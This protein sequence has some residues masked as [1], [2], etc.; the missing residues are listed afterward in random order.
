MLFSNAVAKVRT[1]VKRAN[2][3]TIFVQIF[4]SDES[5]KTI[6]FDFYTDFN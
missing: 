3:F 6:S 5:K 1:F 4:Y 2:I